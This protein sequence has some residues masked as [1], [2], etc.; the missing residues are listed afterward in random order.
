MKVQEENIYD[1][2]LATFYTGMAVAALIV[3]A[4]FAALGLIPTERQAQVVAASISWNYT[5]W[6]NIIFLILAAL[7]VRRFMKSGGPEMLRMMNAPASQ[8]WTR[9]STTRRSFTRTGDTTTYWARLSN[10]AS[11]VQTQRPQAIQVLN[12]CLAPR[13]LLLQSLIDFVTLW[14]AP[15]SS[16]SNFAVGLEYYICATFARQQ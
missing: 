16:F 14:A 11:R 9:E 5:T 12:R 15:K 1:F 2:W 8:A 6:L 4:V 3:E 7:L 13:V 10:F